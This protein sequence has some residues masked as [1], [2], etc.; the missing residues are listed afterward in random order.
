MLVNLLYWVT[1]IAQITKFWQQHL[2]AAPTNGPLITP[3]LLQP[4]LAGTKHQVACLLPHIALTYSDWRCLRNLFDRS[5][6]TG[7]SSAVKSER[8]FAFSGRI[9]ISFHRR[10]SGK[11]D[12]NIGSTLPC[13]C[14]KLTSQIKMGDNRWTTRWSLIETWAAPPM[15]FFISISRHLRRFSHSSCYDLCKSYWQRIIP[16]KNFLYFLISDLYRDWRCGLCRYHASY[17]LATL[18]VW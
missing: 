13:A 17:E 2:G 16:D 18:T 4:P 12:L 1:I 9:N 6:S 14:M 3:H 5:A 7:I 11:I 10:W 8:P 15:R